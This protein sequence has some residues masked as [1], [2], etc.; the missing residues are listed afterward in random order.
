[1]LAGLRPAT[2]QPGGKLGEGEGFADAW[3]SIG[4]T[5][6][7]NGDVRLPE[8]LNRFGFDIAHRDDLYAFARLR[9]LFGEL[10]RVEYRTNL[11]RDIHEHRLPIHIGPLSTGK[12]EV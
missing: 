8:P 7:A 10:L 4:H 1:L 5:D 9:L 2:T 3:V 12:R 6:L 11:Y